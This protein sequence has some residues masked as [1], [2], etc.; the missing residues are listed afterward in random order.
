MSDYPYVLT[1]K[2]LTVIIDSL[3]HIITA[4]NKRFNEIK[5]LVES[6]GTL[7]QKA[8][9]KIYP[10]Q[11]LSALVGESAQFSLSDDGKTLQFCDDV[12]QSS[13][14]TIS[15]GIADVIVDRY[16]DDGDLTP[17]VNFLNRCHKL[18]EQ[19]RSNLYKFFN[20]EDLVVDLEGNFFAYKAVGSNMESLHDR[21]FIYRLGKWASMVR[22]KVN[23][24]Q[25][26]GCASGLHFGTFNYAR[27]FG[28]HGGK[29]LLLKV[30]PEDVV[31]M[32]N[33]SSLEKGRVCRYKVIK[34]L[35][36]DHKP[37]LLTVIAL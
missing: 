27:N 30:A 25:N 14:H 2:A 20:K 24:N 33:D 10:S 19:V 34:T 31:A 9:Y 1:P 22:E 15:S 4:S 3:P 26:T 6:G 16:I 11:A 7:T 32:P 8:I 35:Q 18:P 12:E 21:S 36:V 28:S 23:S 13:K 17:I 5:A 37:K 29:L